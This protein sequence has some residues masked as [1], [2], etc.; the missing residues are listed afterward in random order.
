MKQQET[1]LVTIVTPS[2]NQGQ[3]IEETILSVK[4]QDYPAIEYLVID[5]GSTD[6]TLDILEKHRNDFWWVSEPDQGQSDAINK[7]WARAS[8]DIL[9]FLNSD[10]TL[11]PGGVK[12]AV[13]FLIAHPEVDIV[14][15][16]INYID[17][18]SRVIQRYQA[19][20]FDFARLLT[21]GC[22]IPQQS[23]FIRKAVFEKVG[24]L[25]VNLYTSMDYDYWL[26]CVLAGCVMAYTPQTIGTWRFH[27]LAK[28]LAAAR[29]RHEADHFTILDKCFNHPHL[30]GEMRPLKAK[31]YSRVYLDFGF[32]YY[33]A[34]QTAKA[35]QYFLKAIWM[36]P[37]WLKE[38]PRMV[39]F[40]VKSFLGTRFLIF[41]SSVKNHR[42]GRKAETDR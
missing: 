37:A 22:Y 27:S 31:A 35:R 16:D 36:Y 42:W 13:Q 25:D 30:P 1:P 24:G 4:T 8:G 10:D 6:N 5:G 7:G 38:R 9:A 40:I 20:A 23:V 12:A 14:Y 19:P 15:G 21:E 17:E 18:H 2:F 29:S 34:R 41:A 3:F 28:V 11:M 32:N 33:N 39:P 26:Q